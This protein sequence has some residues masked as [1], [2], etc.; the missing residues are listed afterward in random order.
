M[1]CGVYATSK[2]FHV[3]FGDQVWMGAQKLSE[4]EIT[5]HWFPGLAKSVYSYPAKAQIS[6]VC[7][8]APTYSL[9]VYTPYYP[10][11]GFWD[12]YVRNFGDPLAPPRLK[13]VYLF[14]GTRTG[15]YYYTSSSAERYHFVAK[16][17]STWTFRGTAFSVDA[18]AP[19]NTVPLWRLKNARTGRYTLTASIA[20]RDSLLRKKLGRKKL[21]SLQGPIANVSLTAETS[22]TPVYQLYN[23]Y[24]NTYYYATSAAERDVL[25]R[26][27]GTKKWKSDGVVFYLG[28]YALPPDPA[29]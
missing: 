6:I 21:Y 24:K 12:I 29:P 9:Y 2:D 10:Q 16:H 20:Y 17:K 15:A 25:V 3:G 13:P 22:A 14:S 19:T 4:Y 5:Y 27:K 28:A 7:A 26:R 8:N 18:S 1:G 23:K 11:K